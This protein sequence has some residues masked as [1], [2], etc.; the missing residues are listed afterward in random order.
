MGQ[1]FGGLVALL[2]CA[3]ALVLAHGDEHASM[4]M[5]HPS[6]TMNMTVSADPYAYLYEKPNYASL[7]AYSGWMMAHIGLMVLAWFFVLPI[8]EL[9]AFVCV[10]PGF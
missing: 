1:H 2:L 6:H 4:N 5:A 3:S 9:F 7:E 8:G 10:S